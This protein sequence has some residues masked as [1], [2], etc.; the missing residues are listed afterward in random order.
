MFMCPG[1]Q[2]GQNYSTCRPC[3]AGARLAVVMPY[4]NTSTNCSPN[5]NLNPNCAII[6]S[7]VAKISAVCV[8][9]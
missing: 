2:S 5:P 7:N 3:S 9:E 8:A 6:S 4:T 1:I